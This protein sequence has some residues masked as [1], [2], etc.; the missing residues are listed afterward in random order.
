[1][2]IRVELTE[3]DLRDLNSLA[4]YTLNRIAQIVERHGEI[5]GT[6]NIN[7]WRAFLNE[8]LILYVSALLDTHIDVLQTAIDNWAKEFEEGGGV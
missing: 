3:Q 5:M 2:R 1:M 8:M 6:G 7:L 4:H